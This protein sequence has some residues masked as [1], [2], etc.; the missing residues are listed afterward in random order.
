MIRTFLISILFAS[1]SFAQADYS[2]GGYFQNLQTAWAP[3]NSDYLFL[4]GSTANRINFTFYYGENFTFNLGARN[5]LDYG[6]FYGLI[7]NYSDLLTANDGYFNLNKVWK[8]K[9]SYSFY[10]EIDRINLLI[11]KDDFEIQIG[12]QRINL[13]MNLVWTPND[14]FNSSSYLNFSYFEKPGSD[15]VRAQYFFGYASSLEF[16]YKL[17]AEKEMSAAAVLRLNNWDYDFQFFSGVMKKDYVAGLGFAGEIADAGFYGEATYFI[18][19][20]K[21][22]DTN[23]V[24]VAALSANYTFENS[25]FIHGEFLYNSAGATENINWNGGLFNGKYNAKNLSPSRFSIFAEVSYSV[26]PLIKIDVSTI[27]NPLDYSYF[28]NPY[29]DFSLSDNTDLLLLCQFFMGES[30]TEW[31]DLGAFYY[32]QFKWS[33]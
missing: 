12:R 5:I 3:K 30:N 11:T 32:A 7:P 4:H 33:F 21:F 28:L 9:N 8:N 25:L 14:I 23:G 10:S 2:V 6:N 29:I 13:G 18:D 26:T 17:D 1:V 16:V 20:E 15:A 22:A 19:K 24:F 27:F 31:G